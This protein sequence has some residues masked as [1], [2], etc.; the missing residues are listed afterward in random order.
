MFFFVF[1]PSTTTII[2]INLMKKFAKYI[3]P[4]VLLLIGTACAKTKCPTYMTPQEFAR[5]EEKR[6]QKGSNLKRDK[7]GHIKK[8]KVSVDKFR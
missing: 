1:L 4:F 5:Y 8:K 6:I 7:K 2:T 3:F